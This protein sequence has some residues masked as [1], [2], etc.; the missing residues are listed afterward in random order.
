MIYQ[1]I[2]IT[3]GN[4]IEVFTNDLDAMEFLG[5]PE[6]INYNHSQCISDMTQFCVDTEYSVHHYMT[7]YVEA[8]NRFSENPGD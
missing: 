2:A 5:M 6:M 7:N 1:T 3:K 8:E 4:V